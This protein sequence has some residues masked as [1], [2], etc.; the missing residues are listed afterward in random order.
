VWGAAAL[1]WDRAGHLRGGGRL[2]CHLLYLFLMATGVLDWS[3][4]VFVLVVV[5]VIV[6]VVADTL[7]AGHVH[8]RLHDR[9][10]TASAGTLYA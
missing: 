3:S 10:L 4:S 8:S 7:L 6:V 9:H 5:V 2:A 1:Q